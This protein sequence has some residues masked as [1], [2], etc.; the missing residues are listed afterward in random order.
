MKASGQRML[1][2]N[3]ASIA[4]F[5]GASNFAIYAATKVFNRIF[6]KYSIESSENRNLSNLLCPGE[7]LHRIFR[8]KWTTSQRCGSR[9]YDDARRSGSNRSEEYRVKKKAVVIPAG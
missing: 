2:L 7:Y 5:Q 4:A 6:P 9:K 3:V 1:Y 8:K